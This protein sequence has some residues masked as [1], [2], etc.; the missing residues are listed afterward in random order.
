MDAPRDAHERSHVRDPNQPAMAC[1]AL[2]R[3]I[4]QAFAVVRRFTNGAHLR[5]PRRHRAV[6]HIKGAICIFLHGAPVLPLLHQHTI[7]RGCGAIRMRLVR[8]GSFD[9]I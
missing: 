5:K 9:R 7:A 1:I 8:E 6:G 3:R 2:R 4:K